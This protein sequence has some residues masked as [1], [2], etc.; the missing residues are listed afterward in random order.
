MNT[1]TLYRSYRQEWHKQGE[2]YYNCQNR[3]EQTPNTYE[4]KS[5]NN[6]NTL[7]RDAVPNWCHGHAQLTNDEE[8]KLKDREDNILMDYLRSQ[9]KHTTQYYTQINFDTAPIT[10]YELLKSPKK[11][12]IATDGGAI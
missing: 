5:S 2:F 11:L 7:P 12:V 6:I 9:Q 3:T 8:G 1:D 10:I 4:Y